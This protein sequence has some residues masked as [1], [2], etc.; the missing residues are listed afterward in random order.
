MKRRDFLA[1]AALLPLLPAIDL[2]VKPLVLPPIAGE[3]PGCVFFDNLSTLDWSSV[4]G[5]VR[6]YDWVGNLLGEWKPG[7]ENYESILD[8]FVQFP[9]PMVHEKTAD[10]CEASAAQ[11]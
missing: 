11:Y 9:L 1:V 5:S 6:Y 3:Q 4:D 2:E 7:D 10:T 8:L